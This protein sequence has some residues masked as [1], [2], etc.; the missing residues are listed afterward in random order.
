VRSDATHEAAGRWNLAHLFVF[1]AVLTA[2]FMLLTANELG[3]FGPLVIAE[4]LD[5]AAFAVTFEALL[6]AG[7]TWSFIRAVMRMRAAESSAAQGTAR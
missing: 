5:L 4:A 3:P 1:A 2:G 7:Q 6:L